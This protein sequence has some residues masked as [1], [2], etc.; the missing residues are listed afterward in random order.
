[1]DDKEVKTT[2]LSMRRSP[3][4]KRSSPEEYFSEPKTSVNDVKDK[5]RRA[6]ARANQQKAVSLS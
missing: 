4:I 3:V 2:I 1:M 5:L 6:R